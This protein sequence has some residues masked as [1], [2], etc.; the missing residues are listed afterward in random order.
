M[1][2]PRSR[3]TH[4]RSVCSSSRAMAAAYLASRPH[5]SRPTIA[6]HVLWFANIPIAVPKNDV[7]DNYVVGQRIVASEEVV[8]SIAHERDWELPDGELALEKSLTVPSVA[9]TLQAHR[10]RTRGRTPF[11]VATTDVA[12]G[13]GRCFCVRLCGPEGDPAGDAFQET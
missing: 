11:A 2:G 7:R 8:D 4:R 12:A 10:K 9:E 13:P 3:V 6:F 5:W 1:L